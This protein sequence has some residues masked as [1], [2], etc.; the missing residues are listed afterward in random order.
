MCYICFVEMMREYYQSFDCEGGAGNP[1]TQFNLD[2]Q[3][4]HEGVLFAWLTTRG[5]I[6]TTKNLMKGRVTYVGWYFMHR[7]PGED[8]VHLF[9]RCQIANAVVLGD[10]KFVWN[11]M[12]NA[13][14]SKGGTAELGRLKEGMDVDPLAIV[15]VFWKERN[16]RAFEGIHNY[17]VK[18]ENSVFVSILFLVYS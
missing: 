3:G 12:V 6:L 4:V 16:M 18:Y 5:V 10:P 11:I 2:S 7:C 9:L 17:F 14:Y 8:V 15:W 13:G 1:F